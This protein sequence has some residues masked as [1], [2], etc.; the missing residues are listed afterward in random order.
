MKLRHGYNILRFSA[1]KIP[2]IVRAT[3]PLKKM[4]IKIRKEIL[5][6]FYNG[7]F[8]CRF[9]HLQKTLNKYSH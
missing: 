6:A 2:V 5:Q 9:Q 3:I 1:L 4:K 7:S 8:I